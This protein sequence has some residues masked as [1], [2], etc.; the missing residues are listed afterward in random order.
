MTEP[1]VRIADLRFDWGGTPCLDIAAFE[2]APGEQV[3]LHGPSGS[4]KST[5]L[6]L[7]AGVLLPR[8]GDLSI[9]GQPLSRLSGSARDRFRADHIGLIFQQF[10]LIPYL[11]V[12][13]NILLPCRFS[14]RRRERAGDPRQAAARLLRHLDLDESL[15]QRPATALS[16]GQQQRVAA[17][18][19]LIGTP[20]LVI[21]D[22]PTSALDAERQTAFLDLLIKECTAAGAALV[23]VSHDRRLAGRFSRELA[24][25][26]INRTQTTDAGPPS[27]VPPRGAQGDARCNI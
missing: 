2:L 10:N 3:F 1:I 18:R 16:V 21:A 15:W 8:S 20:E 17:A 26:E 24:L 5:L 25:T 27:C 14:E 9:L 12:L 19:A 22:E 7:L 13:D 4:G 23:F 6:N 11:S